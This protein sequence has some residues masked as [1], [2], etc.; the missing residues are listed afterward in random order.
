MSWAFEGIAIGKYR[1][2]QADNLILPCMEGLE[3]LNSRLDGELEPLEIPLL[4]DY[5]LY[6]RRW[7]KMCALRRRG[8]L[9]VWSSGI[10]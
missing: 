1:E 8:G 2:H 7:V 5:N 9:W 10:T 6:L 4:R 3:T